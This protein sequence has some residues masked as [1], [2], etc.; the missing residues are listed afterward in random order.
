MGSSMYSLTNAGHDAS[1]R[2]A[3]TITDIETENNVD[4]KRSAA[5]DHDINHP[6]AKD[7]YSFGVSAL[8]D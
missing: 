6:L 7:V 8:V 2:H 5:I 3:H 1:P 4:N